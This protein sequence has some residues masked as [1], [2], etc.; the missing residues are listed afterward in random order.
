MKAIFVVVAKRR[1]FGI[2]HRRH[3][4]GMKLHCIDIN[5]SENILSPSVT[6]N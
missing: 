3:N 1:S 6:A 2:F 5:E 4:F